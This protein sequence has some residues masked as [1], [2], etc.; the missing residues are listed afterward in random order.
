MNLYGRFTILTVKTLKIS[1]LL[2]MDFYHEKSNVLESDAV[3]EKL[4]GLVKMAK[5]HTL[6]QSCIIEY[7]D[8]QCK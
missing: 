2:E 3:S 1:G 7:K 8:A 6:L 5:K 4:A